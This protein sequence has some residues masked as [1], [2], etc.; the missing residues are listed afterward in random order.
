VLAEGLEAAA[1]AREQHGDAQAGAPR[2]ERSGKR[3]R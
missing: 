3:L 1:V 2:H